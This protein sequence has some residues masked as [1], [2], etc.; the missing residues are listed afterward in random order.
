MSRKDKGMTRWLALITVVAHIIGGGPAA[1]DYRAEITHVPRGVEA[2]IVEG[3]RLW[4][5]LPDGQV[6]EHRLYAAGGRWRVPAGSAGIVSGTLVRLPRPAFWP[7]IVL[8]ILLGLA[9]A[10]AFKWRRGAI[11]F[12]VLAAVAAVTAY[13]AH[14]GS[15]LLLILLPILG[16]LALAAL[17]PVRT[18]LPAVLLIGAFGVYTGVAL[19]PMIWRALPLT[20]LPFALARATVVVALVC[21]TATCVLYVLTSAP[22]RSPPRPD[23]QA[24]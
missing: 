9:G 1:V 12:P 3:D 19:A 14:T 21:G 18:R 2:R 4:L 11:V 5:R 17:V 20:S 24:R 7:W 22:G 15:P 10:A 6:H 13:S 8:G 23:R 16:A